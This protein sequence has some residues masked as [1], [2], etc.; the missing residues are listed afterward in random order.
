MVCLCPVVKNN[1]LCLAV[2]CG[3]RAGTNHQRYNN[4]E[5]EFY[6]L[7]G[8]YCH[9]LNMISHETSQRMCY[10]PSILYAC[11]GGKPDGKREAGCYGA[12]AR[13]RS[14][15][16]S[17]RTYP[18]PLWN[19]PTIRYCKGFE[20]QL[21]EGH[22]SCKACVE[23][24]DSREQIICP[25]RCPGCVANFAER[26][27]WDLPELWVNLKYHHNEWTEKKRVLRR[28]EI[29]NI[30]GSEIVRPALD[31]PRICEASWDTTMSR[32]LVGQFGKSS[33]VVDIAKE[34]PWLPR[35]PFDFDGCEARVKRAAK[36][37]VC[38]QP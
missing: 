1:V 2:S 14:L 16:V 29:A 33:R 38:K 4:S 26:M 32:A 19:L 34:W 36:E 22:P 15:F 6:T 8:S 28:E 30:I 25:V 21:R 20:R 35:R 27:E 11:H 10:Y 7:H 23:S 31:T 37:L 3:K 18:T 12:E 17:G 9:L 24:P 5:P 13:K